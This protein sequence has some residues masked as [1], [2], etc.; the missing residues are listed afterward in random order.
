MEVNDFKIKLDTYEHGNNIL[1]GRTLTLQEYALL[2]DVPYQEIIEEFSEKNSRTPYRKA[3]YLKEFRKVFVYGEKPKYN[4]LEAQI[5]I[6]N[7][8]S[9]N[10]NKDYS[11]AEED[12]ILG[13][14][15]NKK[16][17]AELTRINLSKV[18]KQ[19]QNKTLEFEQIIRTSD[20]EYQFFIQIKLCKY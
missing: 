1:K 16:E 20:K 8:K 3:I 10:P 14:W 4:Y 7:L 12:G 17:Y 2:R 5:F 19:I 18:T 13:Y 11:V 15:I 6:L 9:I